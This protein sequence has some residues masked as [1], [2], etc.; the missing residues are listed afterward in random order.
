MVY[1]EWSTFNGTYPNSTSWPNGFD[2]TLESP[3]KTAVDDLFGFS[4]HQLYPIFPKL[5][6]PYNT[7]F[8]YSNSY[9]AQAVYL[10]VTSPTGAYTLCSMRAALGTNCSTEYHSSGSG[11]SMKTNCNTDDRLAYGM[12]NPKAPNGMW[13]PDWVAV[14]SQWGLALSLNA[15]ITDGMASN[16]RLLAQLI[17]K[18]RTLDMSLPSISEALAVLASCT[19]IQ[20]ALDSPFIHYWNYSTTV[21]TLAD[22]QYQAFNASLRTVNF[23]SGGTQRWQSIFYIVLLLVFIGNLCCLIYF[24]ASGNLVTDFVEPQNLFCLSLLSPPNGVLEGTC[25]GG[26]EK[27]HYNT[28][29][30]IKLDRSREHVWFEPHEGNRGTAHKYKRSWSSSSQQ[31]EYEMQGSPVARMYSRIR[32]KRSSLL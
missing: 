14:A 17:P 7:V 19:L 25:A 2:L 31:T 32:K 3:S 9:G 4:E 24:L 20:S 28:L 16:A 18:S 29:W 21:N 26:P 8:N 13:I 15:G 27:E 11:A 22:P 23:Q 12:S 30:N 1:A 5:P 6:Q 10:L